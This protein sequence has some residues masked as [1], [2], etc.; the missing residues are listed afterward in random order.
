LK[1]YEDTL[2]YANIVN[3]PPTSEFELENEPGSNLDDLEAYRSVYVNGERVLRSNQLLSY[4]N[5]S[6][7]EE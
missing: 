3:Q 5:N 7:V 1:A 4:N 6:V 2:S